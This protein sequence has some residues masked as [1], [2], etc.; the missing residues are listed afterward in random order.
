MAKNKVIEK[1][2]QLAKIRWVCESL[3]TDLKGLIQEALHNCPDLN[4]RYNEIHHELEML[5]KKKSELTEAINKAVL[6]KKESVK[7]ELLHAVFSLGRTT[8]DT[9]KLEGYAIA[10]PEINE[11]KKTGSPSV[12][13]REVKSNEVGSR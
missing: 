2:D 12:S 10:H 9:K 8:W 5:A 11:L 6:E 13:I 7:G 3:D 4:G 1:L